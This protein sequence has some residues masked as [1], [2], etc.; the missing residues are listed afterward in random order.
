[1]SFPIMTQLESGQ[2]SEL[3][4]RLKLIIANIIMPLIRKELLLIIKVLV[5]E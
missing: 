3:L 5:K 2:M 4:M 1:M